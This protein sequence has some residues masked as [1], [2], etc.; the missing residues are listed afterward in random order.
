MARGPIKGLILREINISQRRSTPL[1]VSTTLVQSGGSTIVHSHGCI[2]SFYLWRLLWANT[3]TNIEP[4]LVWFCKHQD[5]HLF[6]LCGMF[7]EA[8]EALCIVAFG[9]VSWWFSLFIS[10]WLQLQ[11]AAN[12]LGQ[13]CSGRVGDTAT[14]ASEGVVFELALAPLRLLSCARMSDWQLKTHGMYLDWQ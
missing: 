4:A 14:K 6:T 2:F 12:P 10:S 1:H 8:L 7:A 9:L 13:L 11:G 5:Y 3:L